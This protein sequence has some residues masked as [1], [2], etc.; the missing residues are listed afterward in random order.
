MQRLRGWFLG[1][2]FCGRSEGGKS[3]FAWLGTRMFPE[4]VRM[5]LEIAQRVVDN[6]RHMLAMLTRRRPI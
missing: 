1:W 6:L 2:S 5:R 3:R 4:Y